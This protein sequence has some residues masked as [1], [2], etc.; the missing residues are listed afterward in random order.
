[1]C[2]LQ[3]TEHGFFGNVNDQVAEVCQTIQNDK[4]FENGYNA[5]GFSQGAQFL[6]SLIAPF[7]SISPN[8]KF[9]WNF[10]VVSCMKLLD[11]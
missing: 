5:I 6:Y 10:T 7:F 8:W 11:K 9:G 3:D 4:K 1:M 2:I